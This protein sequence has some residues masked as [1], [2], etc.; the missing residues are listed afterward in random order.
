VNIIQRNN[1]TEVNQNFPGMMKYILC[2]YC[3][4]KLY[5]WTHQEI[6]HGMIPH[7]FVQSALPDF[8]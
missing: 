3:M 1:L 4:H 2:I 8:S 6:P 7:S 5:S